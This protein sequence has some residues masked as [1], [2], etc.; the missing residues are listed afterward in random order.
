[1]SSDTNEPPP[2]STCYKDPGNVQPNIITEVDCEKI[3]RYIW[4]YQSNKAD[5]DRCPMLEIC[6]VQIFGCEKGYYGK[7][8]SNKCEHCKN[9]TSCGIRSG[10]CDDLGCA[11]GYI[12]TDQSPYCNK[13]AKT[14]GMEKTVH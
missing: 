10:R 14:V 7:N 8:C 9:N 3:A 13:H 1:M 2:R 12:V 4:I 6:E 11:K 5:R